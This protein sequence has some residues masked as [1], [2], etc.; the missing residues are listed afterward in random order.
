MANT[1]DTKRLRQKLLDLAVRGKLVP[2]DP[3]DEPASELLARIHAE[4]LEMVK[5]GELKPKDVKNDTVIYYAS[6][7]LP[8]EKRAD[9]KGEAKCISE[10]VPFEL[11]KGWA[12]ARLG[13]LGD[14]KAGATPSKSHPEYYEN[15]DV[16]WLL[17]GDLND[18]H[19]TSITHS[20]TKKAL[21]D[22][23][24]RL[25]PPGTILIAM[26][27]ATIGKTGILDVSATTNQAC[28]A[29]IAYLDD[30]REWI[31]FWLQEYKPQFVKL[32]FG[33]AQQN[34]SREKIVSR[35][36]P[37]PPLSEQQRIVA[38]L[39]R[40]LSLVDTV[41]RDG[42]ELGS[43][44]GR[45][46]SK[47]LDL[48]IRGEL[49]AR[50][51]NDEPASELLARI[52]D[53]KLEMVKRGELKPKDVKGD[54]IIF[55]GSDGLRYEKPADGRGE[56]VCIEDEIPFEI[57]ETWTWARLGSIGLPQTKRIPSGDTFNYIDIGNI[58]NKRHAI[59]GPN[60]I[61]VKNAPSR[62]SRAVHKHSTVFSM[63]RPYLQNIAFVSDRYKDSVASTGFYVISPVGATFNPQC[64]YYFML[65]DYAI[66]SVNSHMKGDNSPSVR[67]E[68][69]D[70]LI[71]PIPPAAEQQNIVQKVENILSQLH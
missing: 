31:F 49:T 50:D 1:L 45:L 66:G 13:E 68:D 25:N 42:E 39:D 22:C 20:I 38:A 35:L 65:S 54:T 18:G 9:G 28:C 2:Q 12:W 14:W 53:E 64:L 6:D 37:V 59:S 17:T 40:R 32:G 67:K 41:E 46:R 71:L 48:A 70:G 52:H 33:G 8:Y 36:V 63:V 44:F 60:I 47:V 62:A 24:V 23:S 30:L 26:Y 51:P 15:G 3:N 58:D 21:K 56:A 57:P 43:L 4:K 27:G 19:I 11:P 61:N 10:E 69:M 5:R 7:G 34:I 16:P 55:T 29:C